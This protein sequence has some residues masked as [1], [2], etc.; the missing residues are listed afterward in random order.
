MD[1]RD[2]DRDHGEMI[3]VRKKVILDGGRVGRR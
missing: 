1:D 3:V 2:N